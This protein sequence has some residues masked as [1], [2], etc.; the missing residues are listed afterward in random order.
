MGIIQLEK[1][2]RLGQTSRSRRFDLINYPS[3]TALPLQV[4]RAAVS[5]TEASAVS[6]EGARSLIFF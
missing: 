1:A 4:A 5:T 2:L 3:I 6:S